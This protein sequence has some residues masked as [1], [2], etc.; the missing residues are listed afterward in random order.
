MNIFKIFLI[1]VFTLTGVAVVVGVSVD[2]VAQGKKVEEREERVRV[3]EYLNYNEAQKIAKEM[4]QACDQ[5]RELAQ[6]KAP[7]GT[8]GADLRRYNRDQNTV[9][10][11]A[12]EFER[13]AA[14]WEEKLSSVG[15]DAQLANVDLQNMLQ[16][17]QQTLQQMSNI[18]K[19]LHDTAMAIIRKIGG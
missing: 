15:D 10:Q 8:Q 4:Q 6:T 9:L 19:M 18:S 2:A 7:A 5:L 13:E 3:Q 1:T 12:D 17:Q 14:R 16:K 11:V